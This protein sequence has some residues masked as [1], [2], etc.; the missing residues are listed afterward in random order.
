MI[1]LMLALLV[2]TRLVLLQ[3][4]T[5]L[6]LRAVGEH[7][8]AADTVGLRPSGALRGWS[9]PRAGGPRWRYLSIGFVGSFKEN[10]TA[11]RGFI[12]LAVIFG[13]WRPFGACLLF[14]FASALAQRLQSEADISGQ[15]A[16]HPALVLTLVTLVE[17]FG[18]S[19]AAVGG[20][21]SR[22]RGGWTAD[23][24]GQ[25]LWTVTLKR[26][27]PRWAPTV[28]ETDAVPHTGTEKRPPDPRWR[29]R[30]SRRRPEV[31]QMSKS[32]PR[33]PLNANEA[34]PS[35]GVGTLKVRERRAPR[36]PRRP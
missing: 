9:A 21:M 15:P 35:S 25:G 1:W 3:A 16:V 12:G 6:E 19:P 11:G 5:G 26:P 27:A 7:P 14:G 23:S 24:H 29:L 18:R 31:T 17:L 4:P 30:P 32:V 28:T 20:P 8:R 36:R 10:I 34:D 2:L 33:G 22:D 13:S